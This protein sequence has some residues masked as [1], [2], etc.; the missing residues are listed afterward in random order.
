[1]FDDQE[2]SKDQ[3]IY[4]IYKQAME[5]LN[6]NQRLRIAYVLSFQL[7][8]KHTDKLPQ[9]F[10]LEEKQKWILEKLK[11]IALNRVIELRHRVIDTQE[12][13][14]YF[15]KIIND[16][17]NDVWNYHAETEQMVIDI[18][19]ELLYFFAQIVK[20]LDISIDLDE[21]IG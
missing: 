2:A 13:Y 18:E 12:G 6:L 3:K 8:K 19:N 10:K 9:D 14:K 16:N 1:M 4:D 17:P 15:D 20:T 5:A 21:L 11:S 7:E